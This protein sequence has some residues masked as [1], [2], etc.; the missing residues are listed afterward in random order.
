[1][2]KRNSDM[3]TYPFVFDWRAIVASFCFKYL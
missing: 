2:Q 1:M 3:T